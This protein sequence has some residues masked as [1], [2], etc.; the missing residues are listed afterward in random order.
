MNT[1]AWLIRFGH[2]LGGATWLGGY[3][4]LA[5]VIIPLL[6][7][8]RSEYL[9]QLAIT[10]V[11][12]M[13]YAG[14][15]TIGFGLVLITRTRGFANLWQ[16]EWGVLVIASFV[17]AIALM[18]IGDGALRPALRRLAADGDGSAAQRWAWVGLGL[19]VLAIAMMTRTIYAGS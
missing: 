8:Q 1:M 14:T 6:E 2:V 15:L 17:V 9:V 11:R 4:I 5:V 16:G 10:A 7:R 13:T 19:T 3:V 18:G 12:V